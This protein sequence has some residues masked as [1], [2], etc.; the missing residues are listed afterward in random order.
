MM[1]FH[2]TNTCAL[3]KK[4]REKKGQKPKP[5]TQKRKMLHFIFV[6]KHI[7]KLV[8]EMSNFL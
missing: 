2:Y 5:E 8:E 7:N 3:K 1:I 4:K 6:I